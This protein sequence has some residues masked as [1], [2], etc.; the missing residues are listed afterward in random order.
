MTYE[1]SILN[2]IRYNPG[3]NETKLALQVMSDI[4]ISQFSLSTFK[5]NTID[6]SRAKKLLSVWAG[7][8]DMTGTFF[9]F[10]PSTEFII[11]GQVID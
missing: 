3:I 2:H 1:E 5:Q 8:P 11:H 9:Y 10:S 6:L 7:G 4:G